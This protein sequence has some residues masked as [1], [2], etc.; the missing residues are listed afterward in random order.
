MAK[1]Q[2][3][4]KAKDD[5]YD[6]IEGG[7]LRIVD[8]NDLESIDKDKKVQ[9]YVRLNQE[10]YDNIKLFFPKDSDNN[11]FRT[12]IEENFNNLYQA[13]KE[14]QGKF[15]KEQI[16]ILLKMVKNWEMNLSSSSSKALL[17][18]RLDRFYYPTI[19]QDNNYEKK[20]NVFNSLIE[21]I[22]EL[23]DFHV[24]ALLRYIKKA[25]NSEKP[26]PMIKFDLRIEKE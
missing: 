9:I 16:M 22:N 21:I 2:K 7:Q 20:L 13:I 10:N 15:S 17:I 19:V 24:Y 5:L 18:E 6:E 11:I 8:E 1:K 23:N 3:D 14:V 26:Y 25:L 12:F 4:I